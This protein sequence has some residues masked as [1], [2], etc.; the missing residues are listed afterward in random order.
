MSVTSCQKPTRQLLWAQSHN[1]KT[2]F[3]E[4]QFPESYMETKFG[5]NPG[6]AYS[7]CEQLA[8]EHR[9]DIDCI[10]CFIH[11][12]RDW[13]GN[14]AWTR[15]IKSRYPVNDEATEWDAVG[16]SKT[17]AAAKWIDEWIE[18]SYKRSA[19]S[20]QWQESARWDR[21]K[22]FYNQPPIVPNQMEQ[23][24]KWPFWSARKLFRLPMNHQ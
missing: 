13:H 5:L 3:W 10:I 8:T 17:P 21:F 15:A 24:S 6:S 1:I 19:L 9:I 14:R 4:I 16:S 7:S 12:T 20:E 2:V 18:A 23:I 22:S 11:H